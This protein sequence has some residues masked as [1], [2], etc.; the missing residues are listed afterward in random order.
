VI[1]Y[2][3]RKVGVIKDTKEMSPMHKWTMHDKKYIK[4]IPGQENHL[5]W[6]DVWKY[7]Q[8]EIMHKTKEVKEHDESIDDEIELTSPPR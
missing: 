1:V 4:L 5:V 8:T 2:V 7:Y 3:L 6:D